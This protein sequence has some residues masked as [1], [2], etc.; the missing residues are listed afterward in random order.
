[1]HKRI[2][3][4]R[5]VIEK[6]K[7]YVDVGGKIFM[8]RPNP[9][10]ITEVPCQLVYFVSEGADHKNSGPRLYNRELRIAVESVYEEGQEQ[11]D[12]KLDRLALETEI[13]L[14]SDRTM[15]GLVHEVS[16]VETVPTRIAY[17]G[18]NNFAGLRQVFLVEYET[19]NPINTNDIKEFLRAYVDYYNEN[20]QK[21]AEDRIEIRTS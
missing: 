4:R 18:E 21:L 1:M 13:I 9:L 3:I 17:E 6:L 14:L 8:S 7:Q 12:E 19:E 2:D 10:F 11:V 20:N 16:I 15:N 5:F